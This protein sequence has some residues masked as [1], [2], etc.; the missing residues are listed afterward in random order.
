ME[1]R[2]RV[3]VQSDKPLTDLASSANPGGFPNR[4]TLPP[5]FMSNVPLRRRYRATELLANSVYDLSNVAT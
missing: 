5:V 2:R 4:E 1:L 3:S